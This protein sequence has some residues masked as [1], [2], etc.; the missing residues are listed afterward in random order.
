M[1]KEKALSMLG[2]ARRA[3][4]L[5]MGH[6]MAQQSLYRGRAKCL[7]FCKDVSP[8]LCGE[9]RV[10]LE[11]SKRRVPAFRLPF[12]MDEIHRAVGYRAGVFTADDENFAQKIAE[13]IDQEEI[14]W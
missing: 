3:G 4:R 13:L 8:R 11:K 14:A 9:F 7:F 5:S 10:T 12:T 1:N 2:L 6:D